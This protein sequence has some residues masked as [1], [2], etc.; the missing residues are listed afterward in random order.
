MSPGSLEFLGV[1]GLL[2][3]LDSISL[4]GYLGELGLEGVCRSIGTD[5]HAR[6]VFLYERA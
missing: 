6:V 1:F 2:G 5:L 3:S 4:F